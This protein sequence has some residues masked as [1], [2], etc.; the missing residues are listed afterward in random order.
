LIVDLEEE[1]EEEEKRG[2]SVVI[3]K[4]AKTLKRIVFIKAE[5]GIL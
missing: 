5:E 4:E 2:E 3:L 1:E